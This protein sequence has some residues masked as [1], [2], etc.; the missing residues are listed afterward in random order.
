MRNHHVSKGESGAPPVDEQRV[1]RVLVDS[2]MPEGTTMERP[3]RERCI[4]GP[5]G[6]TQCPHPPTLWV[7]R[8]PSHD[9]PSVP[10]TGSPPCPPLFVLTHTPTRTWTPP[11]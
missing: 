1:T 6:S 4:N 11:I 9:H 7:P 5:V 8:P 2:L 10:R 3:A